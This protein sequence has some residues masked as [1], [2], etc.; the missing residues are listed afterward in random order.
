MKI[1]N[2]ENNVKGSLAVEGAKPSKIGESITRQFLK[3]QITSD[4]AIKLIKI[5]YLGS[6]AK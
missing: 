4:K 2:I 3:G 1:E 5:Y 6:V